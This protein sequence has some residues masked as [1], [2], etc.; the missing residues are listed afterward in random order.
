ME[1]DF[2][3]WNN[4][5]KLIEQRSTRLKYRIGEVWYCYFGINIGT[6]ECGKEDFLRPVI[7][8]AKNKEGFICVPTSTRPQKFEEIS[9]KIQV[10][11]EI[12][13]AMLFQIQY[14]DAKRLAYK[15]G[16]I[17]KDTYNNIINKEIQI[18]QKMIKN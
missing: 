2:D 3:G 14:K 12:S 13:Y 7:L 18:F 10:N 15:K 17:S 11:G 6:E 4:Y 8:I 9:E 5:K 16:V 1:K